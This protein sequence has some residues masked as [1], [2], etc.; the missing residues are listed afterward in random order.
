M[1]SN[2]PDDDPAMPSTPCAIP[3]QDDSSL[4]N[5][6]S[7]QHCETL[8]AVKLPYSDVMNDSLQT[9]QVFSLN[10]LQMPEMNKTIMDFVDLSSQPASNQQFFTMLDDILQILTKDLY[11][12]KLI[13]LT[14]RNYDNICI[15]RRILLNQARE[16]DNCPQGD[17]QNLKKAALNILLTAVL[18]KLS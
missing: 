10:E 2:Y 3:L 8:T 13:S 12:E 1:A 16:A 7:W 17:Q 9:G 6:C 5:L 15:Y 14:Q 18:S 4:A 11:I